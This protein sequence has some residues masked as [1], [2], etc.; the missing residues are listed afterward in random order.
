MDMALLLMLWFSLLTGM[1]L[2]C[3]AVWISFADISDISGV[4][5]AGVVAL[6]S[7]ICFGF[8]HQFANERRP[9]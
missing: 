2:A 9:H 3:L 7:A 6:I 4:A 1:G 8:A 5:K